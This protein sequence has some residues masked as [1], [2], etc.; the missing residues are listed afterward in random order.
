L[1]RPGTIEEGEKHG[2]IKK[3]AVERLLKLKKV[4]GPRIAE[5]ARGE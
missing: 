5:L 3:W 4:F 1:Y 2:E